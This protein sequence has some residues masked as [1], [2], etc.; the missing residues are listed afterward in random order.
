MA[1]PEV[2]S[3]FGPY[4]ILGRLGEGAMGCVFRAIQHPLKREV[5]LK[6]SRGEPGEREGAQRFHR[7]QPRTAVCSVNE[8]RD[9]RFYLFRPGINRQH[10]LNVR[11]HD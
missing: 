2:G 9:A 10:R 5:A 4:E 1:T 7:D 6:V 3:R 11:A 8:K